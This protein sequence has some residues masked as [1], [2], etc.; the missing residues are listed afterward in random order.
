MKRLPQILAA[1]VRKYWFVQYYKAEGRGLSASL[2]AVEKH[3][4]LSGQYLQPL[5]KR[6]SKQAMRRFSV[7]CSSRHVADRKALFLHP[8]CTFTASRK[9]SS[10]VNYPCKKNSDENF[11][12]NSK[13]SLTLPGSQA[14]LRTGIV[15]R[16]LRVLLCFLLVPLLLGKT[17][18]T[19][20]RLLSHLWRAHTIL[21]RAARWRAKRNPACCAISWRDSLS[22][23]R[24]A[25][26]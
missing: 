19:L 1:E 5:W 14:S 11:E 20:F 8:F 10:S 6:T 24:T 3:A 26:M 18:P 2:C 23:T 25:R 13:A 7:N 4:I 16:L 21:K 17:R 9:E 12:G 22:S 15:M